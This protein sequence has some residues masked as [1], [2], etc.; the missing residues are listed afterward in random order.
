MAL[1]VLLMTGCSPDYVLQKGAT[2]E[3]S[4]PEIQ[5]EPLAVDFG[6]IAV[7]QLGASRVEILNTGDANLEISSLEL[8]PDS[9]FTLTAAPG[10]IAP[11]AT[12]EVLLSFQ[13]GARRSNDLLRISSNDA[14]EPL[15]EV[16]VTGIGLFPVLA[17]DPNPYHVGSL[18]PGCDD[19]GVAT[20]KNI[21]GADLVVDN[22]V[23]IGDGF[24]LVASPTFPLT[25][26]PSQTATLSLRF[27]PEEESAYSAE[28][29]LTSND[30][31]GVTTLSLLGEGEA[32]PAE[33]EETFRQP[34]GPWDQV[35]LI[36]YVDQSSSM[37]DDESLMRSNFDVLMSN[38]DFFVAD[39]Q[40]AVATDD[41]GCANNGFITP[42]TDDPVGEFGEALA[43][44]SGYFTE[45][46]FAVLANALRAS[47]SRGC[48]TGL[49]RPDA[50]TMG[51]LVSD[52]EEQ[53]DDGVDTWMDTMIMLAPNLT[54]SAVAGPTSGCS[55]A[56]AGKRYMEAVNY[57]G[58]I[59]LSICER[60]WSRYFQALGELSTAAPTDRFPLSWVPDPDT[61]E[62]TVTPLRGDAEAQ[63]SDRWTWEESTNEVVFGTEFMP[64]PRAEILIEYRPAASCG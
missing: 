13:P 46:G 35:D 55:T 48:N 43:G 23:L 37:L 60:D 8:D 40:V 52:E 54:V 42:E 30:P 20:L 1:F 2:P 47:G 53:S 32:P 25:L 57:T 15:V 29:W 9:G 36:F 41:N 21:G 5:V 10:L 28:L 24:E 12:L 6:A 31:A 14:D 51:V 49:V 58:G 63:G 11:G 19:V 44:P 18:Q 64:P 38:L 7:G 61:L 3:L 59:F 39:Y 27:G 34:D 62:V 22:P 26:P 16:A 17:I 4:G 56:D 50:K 45:A 33:V